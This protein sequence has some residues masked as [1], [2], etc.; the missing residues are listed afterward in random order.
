VILGVDWGER[1][2]GLAISEG[3]LAEPYGVVGSDDELEKVIRQEGIRRVV[4]GLPE[5]KHEEVVRRLGRKLEEESGV[6]VVFWNE[7][8]STKDALQIAIRSGKKRK[9]RR[10][11]D[12]IAAALLLQEYLDSRAHPGTQSS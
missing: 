9:S 10:E 12:A 6:E 8:L 3:E 1:R 11:L 2:I 5:G 4:L 7:V